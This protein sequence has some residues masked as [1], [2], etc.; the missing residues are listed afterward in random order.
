MEEDLGI[1]DFL[2]AA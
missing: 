2:K 1:K